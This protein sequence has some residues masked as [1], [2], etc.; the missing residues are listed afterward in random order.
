MP[1]SER[2]RKNKNLGKFVVN[3]DKAG[4]EIP[5]GFGGYAEPKMPGKTKR[6][7]IASAA[8]FGAIIL[9]LSL[10]FYFYWQSLISSPQYSLALIVDSAKRND[11]AAL[12]DLVDIDAV[13]DD[14]LPQITAKAV[15]LYGRG[16]DK[17][18]ISR[19]A[20]VA[21]PVLPAV[22][23]RARNELPG[24][25]R[26]KTSE[27]GSIPFAAMV[28]AA[29][30]YLDISVDG[31]NATVRSKLPEQDLEIKMRRTGDRWKIVTVR[32]E[33][34]ATTIARHVGQEIIDVATNGVQSGKSQLGIRNINE[35]LNEAEKIFR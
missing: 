11:Q 19:V 10:G 15:E 1:R 8:V 31:D 34:L 21:Q 12:N 33:K 27:F 18:L 14:F 7:V 5:I 28:L 23:N 16:F 2:L 26:Q 20:R 13:V 25:I 35:L 3:T 9:A 6:F 22:K 24:A 4:S 17:D 32:D 30:T 29:D